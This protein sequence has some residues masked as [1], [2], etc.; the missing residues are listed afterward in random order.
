MKDTPT[1]VATSAGVD[2]LIGTAEILL[3]VCKVVT[4]SALRAAVKHFR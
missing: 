1:S 4:G 2:R 3:E